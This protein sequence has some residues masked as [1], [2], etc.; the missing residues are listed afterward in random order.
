[1]EMTDAE[2][3]FVDTNI[4]LAATETN[5]LN[6]TDA[7]ALLKLGLS[8]TLRLFASGQILREYVV[9][10][11]RPIENNGLGLCPIKA[12]E[13]IQSFQKCL[14]I[15]DENDASTRRLQSLIIR[16]KLKGK[17]IHDANTASIMIENG[18]RRIYTL[19]GND[20]KVLKEIQAIGL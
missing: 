16:H 8:G 10:A 7:K 5:R 15:L 17:R 18:L 6:H 4:L 9:V 20:F 1:M 3:C 19:N 14:R 2:P 11:T 13:N 12:V